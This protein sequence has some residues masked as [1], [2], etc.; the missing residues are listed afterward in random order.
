MI[1]SCSD[2]GIT[3][4]AVRR[5]LMRKPMTT[6]ELLQKFKS[7]KTG[8]TSDQLVNVMT[9]ILKRINPVRQ[10]IKS[11][12]Y[13]S[14]KAWH[15]VVCMKDTHSF[16]ETLWGAACCQ[17]TS[18]VQLL[19]LMC[20]K[21]CSSGSDVWIVFILLN[22]W[23]WI[24]LFIVLLRFEVVTAVQ[25]W[26][27]LSGVWQFVVQWIGTNILEDSEAG[28]SMFLQNVDTYPRN[29]SLGGGQG[30]IIVNHAVFHQWKWNLIT[31]CILVQWYGV[32]LSSLCHILQQFSV[33]HG[34]LMYTYIEC[35]VSRWRETNFN[36]CNPIVIT[37]E[38]FVFIGKLLHDLQL[39]TEGLLRVSYSVS[40]YKVIHSPSGTYKLGR[41]TILE[42]LNELPCIWCYIS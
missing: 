3:E 8:L 5:Y 18:Y 12:M 42:G 34:G 7:K 38:I 28:A 27:R 19:L 14:I 9:Q 29:G 2:S 31:L 21:L 32:C 30:V 6:T 11:K 35:L 26:L 39:S 20:G 24:S 33:L 16:E 37:S 23:E 4:D 13:L 15:R 1:M 22:L 17:F 10:T 25:L 36:I 40:N 41:T